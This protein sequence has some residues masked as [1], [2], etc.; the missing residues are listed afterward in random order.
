MPKKLTFQKMLEKY[1]VPFIAY[2]KGK[3]GYKDNGDP[4]PEGQPILVQ[5]TGAIL[6]F[7][8]DDLRYSEAGTYSV[9]D[10]KVYTIHVLEKGQKLEYKSTQYTVQ[11]IKDYSDYADVYIY[12]VRWAGHENRDN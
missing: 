2:E 7:S 4:I 1:S 10:R 11:D 8:K 9:K 12:Y 6:P 3:G 5:M